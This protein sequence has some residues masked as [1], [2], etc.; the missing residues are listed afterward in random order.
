VLTKIMSEASSVS[1]L[2][3]SPWVLGAV[4]SHLTA[5]SD[6]NLI[7]LAGTGWS[8]RSASE[9]DSVTLPV[10]GVE[11]GGVSY[12]VRDEPAATEVLDAFSAR[13]PLPAP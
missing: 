8:M 9:T 13:R 4:G 5:D 10:S 2:V 7:T 11:E 6:L 3:R 1:G 12:L